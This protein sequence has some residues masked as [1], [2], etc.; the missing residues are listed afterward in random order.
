MYPYIRRNGSCADKHI[1][2]N[3]SQIDNW[4][5]S[6]MIYKLIMLNSSFGIATEKQRK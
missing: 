5:L 4:K 2:L 3:H 6:V 1:N